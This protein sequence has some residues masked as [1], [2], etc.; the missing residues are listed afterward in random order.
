MRDTV[1]RSILLLVL[2]AAATA[3]PKH[4]RV[5]WT[6]DPTH[7][8][9]VSWSTPTEAPEQL[10]YGLAPDALDQVQT[11]RVVEFDDRV[12]FQHA[13]LRGLPAGSNIH[14]A[15]VNAKGERGGVHHF[16]TAPDDDR[17]FRLLSGGDSRTG[18]KDR[19]RV[20]RMIAGIV[21]DDPGVIA[22]AH[23][24]DYI[25]SGRRLEL[26][27]D[28]LTHHTETI[29]ADRR[30]LPVIPARGNHDGGEGYTKVFDLEP[31]H[32]RAWFATQI[33]DGFCLLTLNTSTEP[34]TGDQR[35]WLESQLRQRRPA[36]RWLL[37]QY[38]RPLY[39]AYKTPAEAKPVWAP[40]FEQHNLDIALEA[41][42]H[43]IK[44]TVPI[45][46]EKHDPTG[47]T[48]IGEGGL[49][50]PQR[51]PKDDRWYLDPPGMASHGHHVTVLAVTPDEIR[52]EV[53]LLEGGVADTHTWKRRAP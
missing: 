51:V 2:S 44:R 35:D 13:R 17:P 15:V 52:Y 11:T 49:G 40:L 4:L 19:R 1:Q 30:V 12:Y 32:A 33:G 20:N 45:R 8:A 9:T 5:I 36:N 34:A 53:R 14:F 38:H 48:Y 21:E 29:G 50:V 39:P 43:N 26:W 23:G 46:A 7:A 31:E 42:G 6:E 22:F 10:A 16:V 18:I 47:V 37:A 28:W 3:A 41:D 27:N 24:G 25:V